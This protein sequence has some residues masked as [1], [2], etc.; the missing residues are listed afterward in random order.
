[1]LDEVF[2]CCATGFP[3]VVTDEAGIEFD[4]FLTEQEI[5]DFIDGIEV[6]ELDADE[7][8]DDDFVE[9]VAESK[10]LLAQFTLAKPSGAQMAFDF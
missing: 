10:A 8:C 2:E 1:M 3:Q 4:T 7:V 9:D 6:V 5:A